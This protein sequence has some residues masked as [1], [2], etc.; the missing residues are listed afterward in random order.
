[1]ADN[2]GPQP[3]ESYRFSEAVRAP[4]SP[5]ELSDDRRDDYIAEVW[6]LF[7]VRAVRSRI[8]WDDVVQIAI[9][10]PIEGASGEALERLKPEAAEGADDA[11]P[12]LGFEE[13]VALLDK[14]SREASEEYRDIDMEQRETQ[15]E[16]ELPPHK[17]L[18]TKLPCS[19]ASPDVKY[20][21]EDGWRL[22]DVKPKTKLIV[23][24]AT[25][26]VVIGVAL[27]LIIFELWSSSG[28][29]REEQSFFTTRSTLHYLIDKYE[30]SFYE[31]HYHEMADQTVILAGLADYFV[32]RA[33]ENQGARNWRSAER[34]DELT[35][36][37]PSSYPVPGTAAAAA[38]LAAMGVDFDG[39]LLS[40]AFAAANVPVQ[41][42]SPSSTSCA[43]A[44]GGS[45]EVDLFFV[46][47][48]TPGLNICAELRQGV[49]PRIPS[50]LIT[51][52]GVPDVNGTSMAVLFEGGAIPMQCTSNDGADLCSSLRATVLDP[53]RENSTGTGLGLFN[54][55]SIWAVRPRADGTGVIAIA[56]TMEQ[57][58][59]D[60]Q[61]EFILEVQHLNW[62][63]ERTTEVVV[64]RFE[65]S[66][67]RFVTQATNFR[68]AGCY[69]ECERLPPSRRNAERS[70]R[71]KGPAGSITPDYRPEPVAGASQYLPTMESVLL[72]ERDVQEIR[73]LGLGSLIVI[74]NDL[75]LA[76]PD[77]EII[78]FRHLGRPPMR[79]FDPA[80][81]CDE[82]EDCL[83]LPEPIG[84][85][86]KY[87]CVHCQRVPAYPRNATIELLTE[88][89]KPLPPDVTKDTIVPDDVFAQILHEQANITREFTDYAGD[90][91]IGHG[92]FVVNYSI[93][94]MVQMDVSRLRTLWWEDPTVAVLISACVL[95]LGLG[96]VLVS[97]N[98]SLSSMERDWITA[99]EEIERE[100]AHF[101]R[102]VADLVPPN[103]SQRMLR[104]Q[105]VVAETLNNAV[106]VF[107]DICAFSDTTQ[108]MSGKHTVRLAAYCFHSLQIIA[109]ECG[110]LR[111]GS[112]GDT[113]IVYSATA[114]NYKLN[115]ESHAAVRGA[116]YGVIAAMVFS[117]LVQHWPETIRGFRD[118]FKDRSRAS[119]P[120]PVPRIRF[121]GHCGVVPCGI[122]QSEGAPRFDIYGLVPALAARMCTTSNPDRLHVTAFMRDAVAAND[123]NR[124]FLFDEPRKTIVRGQ[125]TV[126]SYFVRASSHDVSN[127]LLENLHVQRA[128]LTVN[129][130]GRRRKGRQASRLDGSTDRTSGERPPGTSSTGPLEVGR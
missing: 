98:L 83:S 74:I 42:A 18:W 86:F 125:G 16:V 89:K 21:L 53:A 4:V 54:V 8:V 103:L 81:P 29:R 82:T 60:K 73:G 106:V 11:E 130:D 96:L 36:A 20:R 100:K 112:I 90:R 9:S 70:W 63:F 52:A 25:L 27:L 55:S 45:Q 80:T 115:P 41:Y 2:S 120:F 61:D 51:E 104:G 129:F 92:F 17:Y 66:V 91:V 128:P 28:R 72:L 31:D 22:D 47:V 24:T 49:L 15:D 109:D 56:T 93:G 76:L 108:E 30:L 117:P 35:K 85:F 87:N 5:H 23:T 50:A 62:A 99:K 124:N 64:G 84:V 102:I 123:V 10:F 7:Q 116:R 118:G 58:R 68:F 113:Y 111:L 101:A 19:G 127:T 48:A 39:G 94:V 69:A 1:M 43:N 75:T 14:V 65:P 121:G 46:P 37:H 40:T 119:E 44:S 67:G 33:V 3:Q 6:D 77:I 13:F 88:L 97:T 114:S 59:I 110:L 71:T 32:R 79:D 107:A 38:D 26:M 105:R 57:F 34:V 126:T 78:A 12:T 122:I 95:L